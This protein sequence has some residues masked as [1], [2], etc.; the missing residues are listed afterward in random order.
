MQYDIQGLTRLKAWLFRHHV[1]DW[2]EGVAE[3]I[4]FGLIAWGLWKGAGG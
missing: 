3:G 4:V 1:S 2:G